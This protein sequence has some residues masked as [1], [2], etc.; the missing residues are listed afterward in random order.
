M[1]E[2]LNWMMKLKLTHISLKVNMPACKMVHGIT[3]P[4][5]MAIL[6]PNLDVKFPWSPQLWLWP[7][8]QLGSLGVAQP[9]PNGRD[10]TLHTSHLNKTKNARKL[11]HLAMQLLRVLLK[12]CGCPPFIILTSS[13]NG[14][15]FYMNP[16]S[17][18]PHCHE[19][20]ETYPSKPTFLVWTVLKLI[21]IQKG[22]G[23]PVLLK[24]PSGANL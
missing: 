22:N 21:G 2:W 15:N 1:N 19:A 16:L 12:D 3:Q 11:E 14:G 24:R 9:Q 20:M 8:S 13:R 17:L 5:I 7:A 18:S 10:V 4:K 23:P 6:K